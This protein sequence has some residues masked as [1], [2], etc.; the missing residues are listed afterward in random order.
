VRLARGGPLLWEGAESAALRGRLEQ[1]STTQA[2]LYAICY[3]CVGARTRRQ[4][5]ADPPLATAGLP[6]LRPLAL[7]GSPLLATGHWRLYILLNLYLSLLYYLLIR[8]AWL[9]ANDESTYTPSHRLT[10]TG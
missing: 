9:G 5:P 1:A 4:T 8:G 10:L 2:M 7:T 6:S 3:M